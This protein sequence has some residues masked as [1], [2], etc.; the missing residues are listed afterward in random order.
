MAARWRI[1]GETVATQSYELQAN[2]QA[3]VSNRN[4][5]AHASLCL[6]LRRWGD[7]EGNTLGDMRSAPGSKDRRIKSILLRHILANRT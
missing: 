3:I 7:G 6:F 5:A 1:Y 4:T 2:L